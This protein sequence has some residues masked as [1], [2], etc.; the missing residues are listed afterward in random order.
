MVRTI[1]HLNS[2]WKC[3]YG[4]QRSIHYK[5][6]DKIN[7]ISLDFEAKNALDLLSCHF[8]FLAYHHLQARFVRACNCGDECD[9]IVSHLQ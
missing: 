8:H 5:I 4:F 1:N 3:W 7:P 6:K 2:T 9:L